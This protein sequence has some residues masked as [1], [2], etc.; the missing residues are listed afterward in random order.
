M[1]E[2]TISGW[3]VVD[4]RS[5]SHR[6]RKSKPSQSEL[7]TNELLAELSIDVHVPDVEVP[8]L[9]AQIDVPEPRVHAATMEALDEQDLPEWTE[10]ANDVI[11]AEA[12]AIR[13]AANG[14]LA[15]IIDSIA[16]QTLEDAP[17][18]ADPELVKDY[19]SDVVLEMREEEEVAID[20]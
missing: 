18:L 6:T 12:V 7:G 5:G 17:G 11:D 19:V 15:R 3:L 13:Q 16:M 1:T 14:D 20:G 4:W 2:K 8:T 9:S 10:A